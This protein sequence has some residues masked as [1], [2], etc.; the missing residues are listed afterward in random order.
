MSSE[1]KAAQTD[2]RAVWTNCGQNQDF[3][4]QI[5]DLNAM[6]DHNHKKDTEQRQYTLYLHQI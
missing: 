1:G 3:K 6:C 2:E 5:Q 4:T